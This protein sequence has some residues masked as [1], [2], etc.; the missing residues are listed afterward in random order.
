MKNLYLCFPILSVMEENEKQKTKDESGAYDHVIKYTGLFGG[1]Q[2]INL[3]ASLVKNKL[4]AVILGPSGL[5][6]ISLYNTATTLLNNSTNLGIPF[7]AVRHISELYEQGH[8]ERLLHFIKVIR[9]WSLVTALLG[10]SAC[11][12]LSPLLSLAYFHNM[13]QWTA[14]LWLSPVVA[15]MTVSGCELAILKGTRQLKKVAV[16]SVMVS[17]GAILLCL[18]VY[19]IWGTAGIVASLLLIAL[20]TVLSM[21]YYSCRLYP[22][23]CA[24]NSISL[25]KEGCPMIRLG[26][27]YTLGGI[28]TAG[29]EFAIRAFMMR[30]GTESD[31]G[32]YNAGYAL[33]VTYAS[34]VFTAMET[35]YFPRL[36]AVNHDVRLSNEAVNRQVEVSLLLIA[37]LLVGFLVFLPVLLPLLYSVSF[38]PVIQMAQYA[39]LG[40]FFR[41]IT[42]PVA[43]LTLAKGRSKVFLFT[44]SSYDI[45]AVL[46]IVAG[47]SWA[48]LR[49]AGIALLVSALFDL[50][51]VWLTCR[52]LYHFRLHHRVMTIVLIQLPLIILAFLS[53]N[54]LTG[55]LYWLGGMVCIILSAALSLYML[56]RRT[57]WLDKIF[58]RWR[59]K[60]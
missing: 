9:S 37:P 48:G 59:R 38:N 43:Y 6:L 29:G 21:C 53:V 42:L 41:A 5:G 3:L 2:G 10:L 36:S 58:G 30:L 39:I 57:T 28:L 40:M 34:M 26:I 60:R 17:L 11:I 32:L 33:T 27:A 14:F 23:R 46:A 47:Y 24:L 12:L 22:F 19:L 18:P 45:F 50:L 52:T 54:V 4:V 8:T 1:I 25:F 55:E 7:S 56:G 51:L 44:E 49:G 16:Q 20:L 13:T 35:D 15:L 31:V